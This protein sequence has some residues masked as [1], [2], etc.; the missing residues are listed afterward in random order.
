MQI[1]NV[2]LVQNMNDPNLLSSPSLVVEV[3]V[4]NQ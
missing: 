4:N 1:T 2:S 3:Y